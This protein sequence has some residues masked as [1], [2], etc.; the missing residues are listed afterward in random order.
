MQLAV[1]FFDPDG[2]LDEVGESLASTE[3]RLYD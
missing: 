1:R 3:K 2:H